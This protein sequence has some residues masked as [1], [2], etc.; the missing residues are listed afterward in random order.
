MRKIIIFLIT[1]AS[2]IYLICNNVS[3]RRKRISKIEDFGRYKPY[4]IDVIRA[5]YLNSENK[6]KINDILFT[7]AGISAKNP[8]EKIWCVTIRGEERHM[9][10]TS[11]KG[12]NLEKLTEK[13]DYYGED[14]LSDW[15]KFS[16]TFN[17]TENK[18]TH[19]LNWNEND[20]M[21]Y[22]I[23]WDDTI[24]KDSLQII[25]IQ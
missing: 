21:R 2:I 18:K 7:E 10:P 24:L 12:K 19:T 3:D 9:K 13:Y 16:T 6:I 8:G 23:G 4:M 14:G 17:C 20:V 25:K 11:K 1:A 22:I 5:D 15:H